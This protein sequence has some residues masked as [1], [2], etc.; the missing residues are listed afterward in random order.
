MV[1]FAVYGFDYKLFSD[2]LKEFCGKIKYIYF[3]NMEQYAL[4]AKNTLKS[5]IN[6]ILIK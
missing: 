3:A 2:N 4:L 5:I 6:N 1:L